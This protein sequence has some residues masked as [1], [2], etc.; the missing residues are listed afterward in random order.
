LCWQANQSKV[1][2]QYNQVQAAFELVL[3]YGMTVPAMDMAAYH[4]LTADM[5]ALQQAAEDVE[6]H[7]EEQTEAFGRELGNGKPRH[8]ST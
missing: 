2:E 6:A 3:E 8:P 1:D 4:T 7:Q 5:N